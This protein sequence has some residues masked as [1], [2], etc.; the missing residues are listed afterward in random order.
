VLVAAFEG[1]NDAGE[2]ATTAARHLVDA[3]D[4]EKVA[5]L[6]PEE[7]HDFTESRPTVRLDDE[8]I[9]QLEWPA[10]ELYA[11]TPPGADR[12]VL[13]LVAVEPQLRWRTYTQAV[14]G[15]VTELGCSMAVGLGALLADVPHTR[16]VRVTGTAA[17][18]D[19]AE[20]LH[21]IRSRYEGPTGILGVLHQ[22][23]AATGIPCASLW[24]SVPHYV[25]RNPS[26]PAAL[27]LVE[28]TCRLIGATVDTT[29][30]REA[31]VDYVSEVD[32]VVRGDDEA[33]AYVRNL[34][35]AIE[36][37]DEIEVGDLRPPG[38]QGVHL[39]GADELAEEVERFLREHREGR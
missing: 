38:D 4:A 8:G 20:R 15:I 6:D 29:E 28:R 36:D 35:A 31:A 23:L 10:H 11:A 3:W 19:L 27:A 32:E 22:G 5:E 7:L 9:R 37:E 17:D 21:L 24:A 13:L 30:L 12:D 14:I 2:A 26:P 33:E 39:Q 25:G 18:P 34:E 1:W 16:P